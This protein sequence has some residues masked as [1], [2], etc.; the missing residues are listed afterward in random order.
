[1]E[2]IFFVI[3]G[4]ISRDY[5]NMLENMAEKN[6][7]TLL[8]IEEFRNIPFGFQNAILTFAIGLIAA[9]FSLV[10]IKKDGKFFKN[11]NSWR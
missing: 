2:T 4:S 11:E 3:D 10:F 5:A 8:G 9:F 1:M 6:G 7:D